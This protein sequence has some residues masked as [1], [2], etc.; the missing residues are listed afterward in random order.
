MCRCSGKLRIYEDTGIK[1]FHMEQVHSL[2]E[3]WYKEFL[4]YHRCD[5]RDKYFQK[6]RKEIEEFASKCKCNDWK[7]PEQLFKVD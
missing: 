4:Y 5:E 1:D 6:Y 7:K 3:K 2:K